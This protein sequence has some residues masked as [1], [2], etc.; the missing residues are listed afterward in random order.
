MNNLNKILS[1]EFQDF[2]NFGVTE[3]IDINLGS[4]LLNLQNKIYEITKEMIEDHDAG[5][6]LIEK[7]RL[8]FKSIPNEQQW[9]KIM[10]E[11]NNCDEL[12]QLVNSSEIKEKFKLIFNNPIKYEICTFRAR[13]P[14]QKRVVYNWHQD[15]GTWYLTKN[16]DLL[17]KFTATMWLSV[18][19]SDETNSIQ[20]IKNSHLKKKLYNHSFIKGQGYFK[21]KINQ[22]D[23]DT[24]NIVKVQTKP[25]QAIIFH[26]LTLHR[27]SPT[28]NQIDHRPRYSID[29]RYYDIE[30]KLNY[31]TNFL[32]NLKKLFKL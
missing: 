8:P 27:S 19:G 31:S 20:I 23:V 32:F 18:N 2:I 25:S 1:K 17:K 29:I 3:V 15:E 21:A 4:K 26:P 9:A 16:S 12:N 28:N 24:N 22:N 13:Y 7:I 30:K 11:I 6:S 14:S 10:N 5:I